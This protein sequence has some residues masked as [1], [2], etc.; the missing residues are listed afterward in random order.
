MFTYNILWLF[1]L[2]TRATSGSFFSKY[3]FKLTSLSLRVD[4]NR[5]VHILAVS[6]NLKLG[7]G[8]LLP[9]LKH[10]DNIWM[11][12]YLLISDLF[13]DSVRLKEFKIR[14][15]K[16][17][18]SHMIVSFTRRRWWFVYVHIIVFAFTKLFTFM[19]LL[20]GI[21]HCDQFIKNID[22]FSKVMQL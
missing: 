17:S 13:C 10:L 5:I 2:I 4:Q 19:F 7:F 1:S 14:I 6:K 3:I 16:S 22:S 21:S 8:V 15:L 20:L 12:H 9:S 11:E 18:E